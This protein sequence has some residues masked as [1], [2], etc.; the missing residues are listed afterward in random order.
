MTKVVSVRFKDTGKTYF[1]GPNGVEVKKG[2]RVIVE[3][4]RVVEC[5]VATSGIKEFDDD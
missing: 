5:G 2:Q 1:F 4:A 3:T